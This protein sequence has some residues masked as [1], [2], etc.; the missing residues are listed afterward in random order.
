[1]TSPEEDAP[2]GKAALRARLRVARRARYTGP[3]GV[4]LRASEGHRLLVAAAPLLAAVREHATTPA[5]PVTVAVFHPVPLEPDLLPLL[6]SLAG[7]RGVRLL[8]PVAAGPGLL[9]WV[10][11]AP[12]TE[13]G[14]PSARGFGAEPIGPREGIDALSWADLVLAPALA[15][16]PDGSRL[17]HG[18][19]YYDRALRQRRP[20]TSVVGVVHPSEVLPAGE[21]P[22]EQHDLRVDAVLTADGLIPGPGGMLLDGA[23]DAADG[24]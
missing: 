11:A 23:A 20:G 15:L 12:D 9:D 6:S 21:I 24:S 10:A 19:G 1:M 8:F 5:R 14:P 13:I 22:R 17:G 16:A 3:T 18:G 2:A 7:I 4:A